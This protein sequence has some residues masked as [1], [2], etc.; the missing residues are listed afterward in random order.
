MSEVKVNGGQ[1]LSKRAGLFAGLF[2]LVYIVHAWFLRLPMTDNE[3]IFS[4]VAQGVEQGKKLYTE[5]WDHK[6]PL[7]FLQ[8]ILVRGVIGW[9]EVSLHAYTIF[10]HIL[11][12]FLLFVFLKKLK[13]AENTAWIC[14]YFYPLLL[15]SPIIQSWTLQADLLII[16]FLLLSFIFALSEKKY[17]WSLAGIFWACAFFT[18]QNAIMYL[19]LYWFFLPETDRWNKALGFVLGIDLVAVL[20][21]LPF[22]VSGRMPDFLGAVTEFNR[23][24][25]KNSFSNYVGSG[26]PGQF[27]WIRLALPVYGIALIATLYFAVRMVVENRG[28]KA[29]KVVI[30]WIVLSVAACFGSGYL[31]SYYFIIVI[32]GMAVILGI[33]IQRVLNEKGKIAAAALAFAVALPM[34]VER[35]KISEIGPEKYLETIYASDQFYS[36]RETGLY[37]RRNFSSKDRL[38]TWT[39]S[40]QLFPYS[41]LK[42]AAVK[43][44]MIRHSLAFKNELERIEKKFKE[45]PPE[46]IV[47]EKNDKGIEARPPWLKAEMKVYKKIFGAGR[48]YELEVYVKNKS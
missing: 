41:G 48:D 22:I 43:T 33:G 15:I 46:V 27:N 21:A 34:L 30:A 38:F 32:P 23:L 18:K 25:L 20:V 10:I 7:I 40:A 37:L 19:P 16:P 6:P 26:D 39:R 45:D 42:M 35:V 14:C 36:A 4:A 1:I 29:T 12:C 44:P 5:V 9:D 17:S 3:G 13:L 47:V 11:N 2:L 28:V 31:F 8:Y 24:Y